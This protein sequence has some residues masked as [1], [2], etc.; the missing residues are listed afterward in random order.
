MS[1]EPLTAIFHKEDDRTDSSMH[2]ELDVA[3]QCFTMEEARI[4]F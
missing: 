1:I 4:N 2:P 3:S